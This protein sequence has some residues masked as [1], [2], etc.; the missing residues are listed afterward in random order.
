LD[1]ELFITIHDQEALLEYEAAG[2]YAAVPRYR[3]VFVGNRDAGRIAGR[4]DV[5]I[6]RDL[7]HN[8]EQYP[9]LVSLTSWYALVRNDLVTTRFVSLLE[10]DVFLAPDFYRRSLDEISRSPEHLIGYFSDSIADERFLSPQFGGVAAYEVLK[11]VFGLELMDVLVPYLE[12]GGDARFPSQSALLL[13]GATLSG[14][15]DWFEPAIAKLAS[16]SSAGH[17]FE[18]LIKLFCVFQNVPHS[19]LEGLLEHL[20]LDSHRTQIR[21]GNSEEDYE[22]F[23]REQIRKLRER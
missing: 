17:A 2:K 3:Y 22:R 21:V 10:Y 4:P 1:L 20:H 13:S 23:F 14:M 18:R 15:I 5:I 11:E 19:Y 7:P 6:A 12:K 8:I 9:K 16:Y